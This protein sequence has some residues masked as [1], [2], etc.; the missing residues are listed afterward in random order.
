ML[1]LNHN[2]HHLTRSAIKTNQPSS[3]PVCNQT[4]T[5][6]VSK[7]RHI[8]SLLLTWQ[9][10]CDITDPANIQYSPHTSLRLLEV[11]VKHHPVEVRH[12]GGSLA[13]HWN[14]GHPE[15]SHSGDPTFISNHSRVP[16]LERRS[17]RIATQRLGGRTVIY[18]L[19]GNNN[20]NKQQQQQNIK[21]T[22]C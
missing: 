8:S 20:N 5:R 10:C 21:Q 18:S 11:L 2:H 12:K 22:K 19:T 14:V 15:I 3:F 17:N 13:P 6:L 4:Q 16:Y 9:Q 1:H 7:L